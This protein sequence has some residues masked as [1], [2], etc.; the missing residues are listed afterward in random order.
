PDGRVVLVRQNRY[1]VDKTLL[2]IP[3]GTLEPG[4]PPVVCASRELREETGYEAEELEPLLSCYMSPGYS[5]EIIHLFVATGLREV[6]RDPEPDEDIS[7]W[8]GL[9]S[10][11]LGGWWMRTSSRTRRPSSA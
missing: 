1:P 11:R 6:G 3:A 2:E 4:E 5:S 7:P 8:N 9:N 10:R